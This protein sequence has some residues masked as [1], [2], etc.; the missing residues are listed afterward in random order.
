M[1]TLELTNYRCFKKLSLSF[2]EGLTVFVAPNGGG[3]TAV[4]EG[5]AAALRLFVDTVEGR[6]NSKGFDARDIRNVTKNWSSPSL[7]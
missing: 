2:H 3:K 1:R 4:L 7:G 5:V 6:E